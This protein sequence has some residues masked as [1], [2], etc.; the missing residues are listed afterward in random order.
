MTDETMQEYA[1]L[2]VLDLLEGLELDAFQAQLARDPALR[3]L[4]REL[5]EAAAHLAHDAPDASPP[6][7]LKA[8]ILARLDTPAQAAAPATVIPFKVPCWVPWAAAAVVVLTSAWL[9]Q[10]YLGSRAAAALLRD[11]QLLADFELKSARHQ[12]EAERI[13]SRQELS[14]S[15]AG[16]TDLNRALQL[17]RQQATDAEAQLT[18]TQQLLAARDTQLAQATQLVA[19]TEARAR[20]EADLASLK[21]ATLA[22]LLGSSPQALAVA[23]WSPT[24][25]EGVLR[26]E[27]L[28]ALA[29]DKDYQLWLIDPQYPIPVDGGVFTVDPASGAA[30]YAFKAGKPVRAITKFAVSLERKGGVPRAEGPMVLFGP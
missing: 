3:Q 7:A 23:V 21:I 24:R 27:K 14:A 10:L 9:S 2:Y 6:A 8:R 30:S 25:Q 12:L 17:A 29:P 22:S 13:I 11:Q 20:R 18:R 28:P 4:V 26:V 16:S 15:T 1:S 19:D 5:A